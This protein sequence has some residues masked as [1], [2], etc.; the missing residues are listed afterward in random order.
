MASIKDRI[1]N[2]KISAKFIGAMTIVLLSITIL[3]IRYNAYKETVITQ[4]AVKDWTF[5]FAENVRVSLNTLMREGRMDLRFN[6]FKAMEDELEGLKDVRVIRGPRTNEIFREVAERDVIPQME[7][8]RQMLLQEVAELEVGLST[9]DEYDKEDASERINELKSDIIGIDKEISQAR[10][11]QPVDEREKPRDELDRRV[12]DTGEPIYLFQGDDA[13]ILIP[14]TAKRET[15]SSQD[16][17]HKYAREGDVLGAISVEFS[18]AEI[19]EE[20]RRNNVKMA[21]MWLMRFVLFIG[22]IALLLAFIIT[23]NIHKMLGIFKRMTEG[24]LSVRAPVNSEDEIGMLATGF[25]KMASS[26]EE[27]KKE[28]DRRLIEIY[29]LYNVSKTLNASFETEQLLLKLVQDISKSMNID[30]MLILLYNKKRNELRV[31]SYT[32]FAEDEVEKVGHTLHSDF[33]NKV[34]STGKSKI[35]TDIVQGGQLAP[36]EVANENINSLIAV[37]FL[38]RGEVLGLICAFKDAPANFKYSDKKLFNN[39][40]EHLAIAL[41]NARLFEQTKKMAITDGL[42]GMYNKRYFTDV[43]SAEIER[44]KRCDHELSIFM[45][46]LD[47]FKHYNDTHGHPAGDELLMQLSSIIKTSIRKTDI[48]CRYGGE[49]FVVI[50]P[51][52]TKKGAMIVAEKLVES[53][54]SY[55]FPH[56]AEQPLGFVSA[57]I[58]VAT[59]P[60]NGLDAEQLLEIADNALYTAK[61]QGRN[62]AISAG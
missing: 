59:F 19:N 42:T 27:T 46:D 40:A 20:I 32:G 45:M 15:C 34:V 5:L 10:F 47:N 50:L 48:A 62:R 38:R 39:V 58:G 36:V 56:A 11:I 30:R 7:E 8:L 60:E 57:S 52:T 22:L 29:A 53:I 26:L 61:T 25:N 1:S 23:N 17:C 44:A 18:I 24:D 4:K 9:M 41:E 55:P 13:R 37:P 21:G 12:L 51:E 33:Y 31:A 16:G 28:L 2:L 35:L 3:D 14:Y 6:M 54:H 49:E 43:F